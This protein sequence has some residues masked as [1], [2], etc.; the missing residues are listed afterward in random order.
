LFFFLGV[1]IEADLSRVMV[2]DGHAARDLART[3]AD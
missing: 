3:R 1:D 2:G